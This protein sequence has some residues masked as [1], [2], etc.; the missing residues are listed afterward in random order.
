[1]IFFQESM[2]GRAGIKALIRLSIKKTKVEIEK[3][4]RLETLAI[5]QTFLI[6]LEKSQ[7][8]SEG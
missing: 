4:Q 2:I 6:I 5:N 8:V 1:M 7:M 3:G